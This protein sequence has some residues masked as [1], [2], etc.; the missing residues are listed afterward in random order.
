MRP[1]DNQINLV[2]V[3]IIDNRRDG[4]AELDCA[5]DSLIDRGS[6]LV[7]ESQ[8]QLQFCLFDQAW[9]E[10]IWNRPRIPRAIDRQRGIFQHV[11]FG[12]QFFRQGHGITLSLQRGGAE[13][14]RK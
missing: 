4:M 12:V 6:I 8:R 9:N 11:Q 14:C 3:H 13:I 2:F 7:G 1:Q 5:N 10:V